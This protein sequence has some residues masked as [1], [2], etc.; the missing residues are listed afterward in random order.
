M[1][2]KILGNQL[3]LPDV[4][5]ELNTI[6]WVTARYTVATLPTVVE[7]GQIYVT[8]AVAGGGSPAPIG[9]QC[10]GRGVGSPLLTEWV[11]VTTGL[12]VV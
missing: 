2:E 1:Q 6:P 7:G 8:D 12:A 10:F 9:A 3:N 5:S 4:T 11:D